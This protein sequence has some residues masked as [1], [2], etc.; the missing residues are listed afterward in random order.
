MSEHARADEPLHEG[1]RLDE[2][3]EIRAKVALD[4]AETA[5]DPSLRRVVEIRAH[6]ARTGDAEEITVAANRCVQLLKPLLE[7]ATLIHTE[8]EGGG[9]AEIHRITM[10]WHPFCSR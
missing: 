3:P 8:L 4:R 5:A 9:R 2:G 10:Y 1:L 7:N 6:P